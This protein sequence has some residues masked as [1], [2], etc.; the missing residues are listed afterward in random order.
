MTDARLGIEALG[1]FVADLRLQ[2]VPPQVVHECKRQV[3]DALTTVVAA[4]AYPG[5]TIPALVADELQPSGTGSATTGRPGGLTELER[6]EGTATVLTSGAVSSPANAAFANAQASIALDLASNLYFSQGLPGVSLFPAIALAEA[7]HLAGPRVLEALAVAF[8]VAGRA[9]LSFAP[10]YRL[11]NAEES[12]AG[13]PFIAAPYPGGSRWATFG[14]AAAVAKIL[15]LDGGQASQA[16]ALSGSTTPI[17]SQP[18]SMGHMAKYGLLGTMA[19]IGIVTGLLAQGGF[20]GDLN[21]LDS[22][23]F[24]RA[25]GGALGDRAALSQDLGTRWLIFDSN[26]KRYP[27]GTHNQQGLHALEQILREQ[28]LTAS[29]IGSVSIGRAIGVAATFTSAKPK[30]YVEAQFSLPFQCAA[31]IARLPHRGWEHA[32]DDRALWEIADR[33]TLEESP[34]AVEEFVAAL[35]AG[36]VRSP[37]WFRSLVRVRTAAG[38]IE[39]WSDYGRPSDEELVAKFHHYAAGVIPPDQIEEIVELSFGLDELD[40][41]ARLTNAVAQ[42]F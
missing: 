9:A 6:A 19:S 27:A 20:T 22:G 29:D 24:Q 39:R 31:L 35:R 26:F 32:F 37:W 21:I 33:V 23:A 10:P 3:L 11:P 42:R 40:D 15:H 13:Q 30:T 16:L 5:G 28:D 34:E 41:V 38:T 4:S 12:A 2:D 14:A 18:A 25:L 36:E 7:K 8:E 17:W 1:Q